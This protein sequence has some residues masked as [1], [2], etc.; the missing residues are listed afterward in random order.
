[1]SLWSYAIS[2]SLVLINAIGAG[3]M[4]MP[5]MP[6]VFPTCDLPPPNCRITKDSLGCPTCNFVCEYGPF[7]CPEMM[8]P[9]YCPDGYLMDQRGCQSC[10]C[11]QPW[12]PVPP[13]APPQQQLP[14]LDC[15]AWIQCSHG[16]C[17]T[18][19]SCAPNCPGAGPFYGGK[20]EREGIYGEE[21]HEM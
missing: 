12:Q 10:D 3:S 19:C 17:P 15:H 5:L 18:A 1:M 11:K 7:I 2:A 14:H 16:P 9:N 8:C 4:F 6:C 20:R 21:P 13:P